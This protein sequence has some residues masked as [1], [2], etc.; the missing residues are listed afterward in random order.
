MRFTPKTK[1]PS[2]SFI[3]NIISDG[4]TS[5]RIDYVLR[6]MQSQL[7]FSPIA[8]WTLVSRFNDIL[9]HLSIK[10]ILPIKTGFLSL[11][12]FTVIHWSVSNPQAFLLYAYQGLLYFGYL[13]PF[14]P[15]QLKS[16]QTIHTYRYYICIFLIDDNCLE[17]GSQVMTVRVNKS[18]N[19]IHLSLAINR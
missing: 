7:F 16:N 8:M 4:R 12:S 10:R 19:R 13:A 14:W 3:A 6:F 17:N 9:A 5:H 18:G 2:T 15:I 1:M 11:F